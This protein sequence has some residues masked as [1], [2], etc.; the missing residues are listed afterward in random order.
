[1]KEPLKTLNDF[2]DMTTTEFGV[3]TVS[4][5]DLKEEAIK[6]VKSQMEDL[7]NLKNQKYSKEISADVHSLK[8]MF[9]SGSME[10]LKIF[11]NITEADL[12]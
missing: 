8:D 7:I 1:M 6:W 2:E 9:K 5:P 3:D 12:Q 11:F 4:K 10:M